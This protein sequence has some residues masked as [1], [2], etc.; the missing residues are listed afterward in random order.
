MAFHVSL[1]DSKP[2]H[3]YRELAA[4]DGAGYARLTD[5]LVKA[6]VWVARRGIWYV[7]VAHGPL[8]LDAVLSRAESAI[9]AFAAG[10]G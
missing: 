2:V 8:E 9:R 5:E 6:G 4:L 7:S 10:A 1:G 3:D